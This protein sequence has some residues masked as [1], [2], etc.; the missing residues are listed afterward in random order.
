A[1]Y[2]LL[3]G[4]DDEGL[5]LARR[6]LDKDATDCDA[7]IAASEGSLGMAMPEDALRFAQVAASE[8]PDQVDSWLANARAYETLGR[9]SGANRAYVQAL[10][11]NK[12]SGELTRA[13]TRWLVSEGRTREAV[14]MARRL[15][16]YAPAL[17]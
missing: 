16:R 12:Q 14:A 10:D 5:Q 2:L 13:Y 8:C 11:A 7:L 6:V 3:A 1:R 4:T 17:M 9:A 15:T